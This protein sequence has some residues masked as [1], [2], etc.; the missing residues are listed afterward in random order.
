M[1]KTEQIQIIQLH[2]YEHP[3][4][5]SIFP[6][7]YEAPFER[8]IEQQGLPKDAGDELVIQAMTSYLQDKN[9]ASIYT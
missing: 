2:Q 1:S 9:T 6:D 3:Q 5:A 7:R 4:G 8:W